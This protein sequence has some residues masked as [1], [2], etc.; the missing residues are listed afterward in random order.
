[1]TFAVPET[2]SVIVN[3]SG[4]TLDWQPGTFTLPGGGTSCKAKTTS[5]CQH[6]LYNM[7]EATNV[8]ISG[9]GI[10]GSILAPYATFNGKGGNVD[11]QVIVNYMS[12]IT[13]YHP[14][15]FSGCLLM[16]R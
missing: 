6:I 12:G 4:A 10:Q 7:Y 8:S 5:F 13:E 3:I 11:G 2:S 16:P 9:I 14:Y 15:Y 1:V